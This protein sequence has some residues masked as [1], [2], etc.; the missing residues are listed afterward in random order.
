MLAASILEC[1]FASHMVRT[2]SKETVRTE[3]VRM[4]RMHHCVGVHIIAEQNL[5]PNSFS[6]NFQ[7]P[8]ILRTQ[9]QDFPGGMGT[10][11]SACVS[12]STACYVH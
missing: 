8:E 3:N 9:F 1:M 10:M 11:I 5:G 12:V 7:V 4:C 6:R 2:N